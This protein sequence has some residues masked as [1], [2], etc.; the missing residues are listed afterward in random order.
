MYSNHSTTKMYKNGLKLKLSNS[1]IL[2]S[3]T[4]EVS[5]FYRMI[6]DGA[7]LKFYQNSKKNS[8]RSSVFK[9][10]E[11]LCGACINL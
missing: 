4:M 8:V 2:L 1:K 7:S 6:S 5:K 3:K 11:L 9:N 10:L